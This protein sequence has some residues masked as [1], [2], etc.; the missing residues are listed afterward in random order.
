M[1]KNTGRRKISS[2][3]VLFPIPNLLCSHFLP[4]ALGCIFEEEEK[5]GEGMMEIEESAEELAK[6][7]EEHRQSREA[8]DKAVEAELVLEE[9]AVEK[10]ERVD[11]AVRPLTERDRE[12]ILRLVLLVLIPDLRK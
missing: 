4:T 7:E 2:P 3:E 8:A 1:F 11:A 9:E 10:A 5:S 6:K 12:K